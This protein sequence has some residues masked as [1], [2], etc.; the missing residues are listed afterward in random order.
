M[1][2][3]GELLVWRVYLLGRE[4]VHLILILRSH[5]SFIMESMHNFFSTWLELGNT[6]H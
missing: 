2:N 5:L 6:F 1:A 3:N 4:D